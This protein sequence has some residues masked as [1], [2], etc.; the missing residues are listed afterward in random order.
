MGQS[1]AV[2][3]KHQPLLET[4]EKIILGHPIATFDEAA[5]QC[6]VLAENI[7]CGLRSD[8]LHHR[9]TVGL[10]LWL[11]RHADSASKEP[12]SLWRLDL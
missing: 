10:K 1:E 7:R 8:G 5:R 4:C 6:A 9:A 11:H 12:F 2:M 3:E